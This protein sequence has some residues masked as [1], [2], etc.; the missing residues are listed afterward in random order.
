MKERGF[1]LRWP[2]DPSQGQGQWKWHGMVEVNGA[3]E[4]GSYDQKTVEKFACNVQGECFC[5]AD[6]W[7]AGGA[8]LI[9]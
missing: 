5:H 6:S 9:T 4:H 8:Q 7:Q 2:C 3:Y 1:A